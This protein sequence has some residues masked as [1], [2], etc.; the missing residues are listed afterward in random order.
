[1]EVMMDE[2]RI[3][4]LRL[5]WYMA[6]LWGTILRYT[7]RWPFKKEPLEDL[8]KAQTY[9]ERLIDRV[10]TQTNTSVAKIERKGL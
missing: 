7:W 5:T 9:L 10:E 1:M 3:P 2:D 4:K 6:F 8:K